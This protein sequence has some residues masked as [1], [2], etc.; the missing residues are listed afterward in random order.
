MG[1]GHGGKF[2]NSDGLLSSCC[3]LDGSGISR[4]LKHHCPD[5]RVMTYLVLVYHS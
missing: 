3:L 2:W 4:L 5:L 1:L